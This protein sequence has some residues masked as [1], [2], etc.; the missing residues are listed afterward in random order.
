MMTSFTLSQHADTVTLA[1][2]EIE[3]AFSRDDGGLRELR[4]IGGPNVLGYGEPRPSVDVQVG[5]DRVWLADRVFVRYLQHSAE[6]HDDGVDLVIVVGIGSLMLYDRY[7]IT[8]TLIARRVSV[9]NVSEDELQ[10]HRVRLSLPWACVGRPETCRF[11]APGNRLRPDVPLMAAA[12]TRRELWHHYLL[13]PEARAELTFEPAPTYAPGLLALHNIQVREALLC[14]Y[15][16]DVEPAQ[17]SIRS[18]GRSLTLLHDLELADWLRDG[19]ALSGGTQYILLL[20]EPWAAAL[21]IF[22]RTVASL[23]PQQPDQHTRW[24]DETAVY[25]VHPAEFGG[26]AGLQAQL[27]WLR[28]LGVTTLCLLPIWSFANRTAHAWDSNWYDTGDPYAVSDFEQLDPTLGDAVALRALVDGAHALGMRVLIDLPMFGCSRSSR[29]VT[30]HPEWFCHNEAGDLAGV[31]GRDE[32]ACFDWLNRDLQA[33]FI[34]QALRQAQ[35]YDIDGYR[36]VPERIVVPNWERQISSHA[37]GGAMEVLRVA[38]HIRDL[39]QAWKPD[40]GI[41]TPMS[42]PSGMA[43]GAMCVD[44]LAHH[45]FFAM[46]L[47]RM[48]PHELGM[49]LA[50]SAAMQLTRTPRICFVESHHTRMLTPLADGLRGSPLS[51]VWLTGIVLCGYVPLVCPEQTWNDERFVR[52]LLHARAQ[53]PALRHG[54]AWYNSVASTADDVFVVVRQ[55]AEQTVIGVLNVG[56]HKRAVT[57]RVPAERLHLQADAY[58]LYEA[59]S[60]LQW[61]EAGQRA[62]SRDAL[63]ALTLTLEPFGTYFFVMQPVQD[64]AD[65]P[66]TAAEHNGVAGEHTSV[67]VSAHDHSS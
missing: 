58:M 32:L 67:P 47:R 33:Y 63:S 39:L 45:H 38:A 56:P 9:V 54:R 64:A 8:G 37:S 10:L 15:Q 55:T 51:R 12:V 25:E 13:V 42:G 46:A 60:G 62:W 11:E 53:L 7:H 23:G 17:P 4:R 57:F 6:E 40:A 31:A 22:R 24:A 21:D 34:D 28:D 43:V 20:G 65:G 44:E 16:S 18:N 5:A 50:D 41:V 52:R 66:P 1:T 61:E 36:I 19:V 3:L 29:Y 35:A 27:A 30:E 59:L 48:T 26:F 49:W 14:W 2:A